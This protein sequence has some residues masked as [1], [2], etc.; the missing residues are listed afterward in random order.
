[1]SPVFCHAQGQNNGQFLEH[2]SSR[3]PD[4]CPVSDC[5]RPRVDVFRPGRIADSNCHQLKKAALRDIFKIRV[6]FYPVYQND[7]VKFNGQLVDVYLKAAFRFPAEHTFPTGS[8]FT[9]DRLLRNSK[10][11][12]NLPLPLR[13]AVSMAS[14]SR[15]YHGRSAVL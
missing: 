2:I 14:H 13:G 8:D 7:L 10:G 12:Q 3:I 9:P 4:G 15:E 11:S 6:R 1:M 5:Q